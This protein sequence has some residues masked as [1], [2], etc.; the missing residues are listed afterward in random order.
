MKKDR[1]LQV[2]KNPND[3]SEYEEDYLDELWGCFPNL[4]RIEV[5]EKIAKE[6]IGL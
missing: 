2:L 3:I 5:L 6:D 1:A 4:S